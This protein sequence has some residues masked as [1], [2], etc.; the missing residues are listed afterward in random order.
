MTIKRSRLDI[1]GAR[2]SQFVFQFIIQYKEFKYNIKH[3]SVGG[4]VGN[5]SLQSKGKAQNA[6]GNT[7]ETAANVT[8]YVKGA[9]D[10]AAGAVKGAFNSATGNNTGEAGN[11]VQEKKGEAQKTFNS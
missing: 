11:K 4:A 8:G 7:E 2:F 9:A 10:Q 5:D 6:S 1:K 3:D